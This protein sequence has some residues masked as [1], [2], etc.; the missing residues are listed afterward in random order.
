MMSGPINVAHIMFADKHQVNCTMA[1]AP[2]RSAHGSSGTGTFIGGLVWGGGSRSLRSTFL[3]VSLRVIF[4]H[5]RMVVGLVTHF[6][7]N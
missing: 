1:Q 5:S 7:G 6:V 2:F 3:W 4:R